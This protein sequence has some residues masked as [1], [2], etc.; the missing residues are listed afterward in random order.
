[1]PP[2]T[3]TPA[4]FFGHGSPVNALGGPYANVWRAIGEGPAQPK[5]ILMISAHWFVEGV[6]LTAAARPRT[7]HD[8]RAPSSRTR[9]GTK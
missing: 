4:L 3:R 9:C 1:L 6:A 5:A 7:I 2:H 8:V